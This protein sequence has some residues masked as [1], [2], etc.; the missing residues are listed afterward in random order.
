MHLFP[1]I[2]WKLNHWIEDCIYIFCFIKILPNCFLT[3]LFHF[4][5]KAYG[6]S[7]FPSYSSNFGV[8]F[9]DFILF[10]QSNRWYIFIC[11]FLITIKWRWTSFLNIDQSGFLSYGL[12]VHILHPF[13]YLTFFPTDLYIFI[14]SRYSFLYMLQITSFQNVLCCTFFT[15]TFVTQGF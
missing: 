1:Y 13:F 10:W 3:L 14:Y 11:F 2:I 9:L 15:V 4:K 6:G 7:H 12:T 5:F 8:F